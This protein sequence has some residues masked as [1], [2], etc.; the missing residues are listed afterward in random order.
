MKDSVLDSGVR[1]SYCFRAG[2]K[3]CFTWCLKSS[4][5]SVITHWGVTVQSS[6]SRA[7]KPPL[8][9]PPVSWERCQGASESSWVLLKWINT[10]TKLPWCGIIRST[11]TS[12]GWLHTV[13]VGMSWTIKQLIIQRKTLMAECHTVEVGL[14]CHNN[15][16]ICGVVYLIIYRHHRS[17][18]TCVKSSF[19]DIHLYWELSGVLDSDIILVLAQWFRPLVPVGSSF[20]SFCS[21]LCS[22]F[23]FDSLVSFP[24]AR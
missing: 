8:T 20:G 19:K 1:C 7:S 3:L 15:Y 2:L 5:G 23:Y 22:L 10:Q 13:G 16:K 21:S 4:W 12:R 9:V 11:S 6:I 14:Q 18:N 17:I 24:S